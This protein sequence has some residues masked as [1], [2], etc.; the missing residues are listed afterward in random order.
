MTTSTPPQLG[1]T[2]ALQAGHRELG[3]RASHDHSPARRVQTTRSAGSPADFAGLDLR[4]V[5]FDVLAVS[6]DDLHE[7]EGHTHLWEAPPGGTH[8]P[9]DPGVRGPELTTERAHPGPADAG[10]VFACT[11][12]V[13]YTQGFTGQ[14]PIKAALGPVV[15]SARVAG[16]LPG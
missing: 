10:L 7:R 2:T 3:G 4:F 6:G 8:R 5:A 11:A 1:R 9:V 14:P 15:L 12:P 13:D 16:A